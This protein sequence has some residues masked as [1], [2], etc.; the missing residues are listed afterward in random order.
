LHCTQ[1]LDNAQVLVYSD[2]PEKYAD[3]PVT[4]ISIKGQIEEYSRAGRYFH[5]LKP[6]VLLHALNGLMPDET[7]IFVDTDTIF[8]K[9]LKEKI[10]Q[11]SESIV[12][13]HKFE[14]RNPYPELK[15]LKLTLLSGRD[16]E[17]S[18]AESIMFNSGVVGVQGGQKVIFEDAIFFIDKLIDLNV[19]SHAI[20][21]FAI[22]EMLRFYGM[23]IVQTSQEIKHY[24]RSTDKRYIRT[25][26]RDIF[27][28]QNN[29]PTADMIR[30]DTSWLGARAHKI[31][32][33]FRRVIERGTPS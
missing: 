27:S 7:L 24:W 25:Q 2:N 8:L 11:V 29:R 14:T 18:V 4:V 30:V 28:D 21:Q 13:M 16:Y 10:R 23:V 6:C 9:P 22:S 5:R 32:K 33:N 17:Y 15:N 26:L 12:L 3:L 1:L 20:E 19:P 31:L